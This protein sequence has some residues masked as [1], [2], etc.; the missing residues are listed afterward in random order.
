M[1]TY[2]K[3]AERKLDARVLGKGA[4]AGFWHLFLLNYFT[5]ILE[6]P[7]FARFKYVSTIL[8]ESLAQASK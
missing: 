2:L 1:E 4:A 7:S 6:Y 5:T 8:S 3:R